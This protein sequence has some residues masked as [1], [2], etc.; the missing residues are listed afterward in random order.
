MIMDDFPH[1]KA[2]NEFTTCNLKVLRKEIAAG[3]YHE[4]PCYQ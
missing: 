2:A 4:T 1:I 3:K